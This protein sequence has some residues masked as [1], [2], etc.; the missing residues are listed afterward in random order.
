MS[1]GG[2]AEPGCLTRL[3]EQSVMIAQSAIRA[4]G[5]APCCAGIIP[6]THG[7]G[8]KC[9]HE[10]PLPS[11]RTWYN[12]RTKCDPGWRASPPAAQ[13]LYRQPTAWEVNVCKRSRF[14]PC[15]RGIMIAQSAIRAGRPAPCC[16]GII[17]TGKGGR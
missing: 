9:L 2:F 3:Y 5:P 7:L 6:A 4:G 14:L 8:S 13:E 10:Q 15:A 12:D 1:G 11:L 16:A 17:P